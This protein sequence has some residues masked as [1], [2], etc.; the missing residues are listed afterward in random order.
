MAGD[1]IV[2]STENSWAN[3]SNTLMGAFQQQYGA[4]SSIFNFLTSKYTDM[5]KN[6]QGFSPAALSAMRGGAVDNLTKQF[7]NAKQAVNGQ[8]SLNGGIGGDVKSGV[9]SQIQGGLAGQQAGATAGALDNIEMAN[10]QQKIDNQR[11]AE[12]GLNNVGVEENPTGFAS[13]AS[14]AA[15][16]V[17]GLGSEYH[18]TDSG[19]FGDA[20]KQSFG[21]G[22]G[23][24]LSGGNAGQGGVSGAAG[25]FGF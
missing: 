18:S 10:E 19:G 1:S 21:S 12:Q 16:T 5:I 15:G 23:K 9:A 3:F 7:Q 6:P 25:F 11:F 4:Q 8:L 17:G 24:T 14:S 13:Q 20:F 22:L 2:R